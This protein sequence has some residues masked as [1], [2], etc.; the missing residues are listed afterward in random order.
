MAIK[1]MFQKIKQP[2]YQ[3]K[4]K[5]VRDPNLPPPPNL[6]SHDKVIR[7][8]TADLGNTQQSLQ[9]Q[10]EEIRLLKGKLTQ[11]LYRIDVLTQYLR[12]SRK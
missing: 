3:E 4:Q 9:Q 11:A 6:L 8:M 5:R 1:G 2:M 7:G 10:Q 12:N